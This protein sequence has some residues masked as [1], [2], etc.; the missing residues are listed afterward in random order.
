MAQRL[1]DQ[2]LNVRIRV[3]GPDH[4]DTLITKNDLALQ[5][6]TLGLHTRIIRLRGTC[7]DQ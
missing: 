1:F 4:P 2:V 5:R 3:F 7:G 6:F